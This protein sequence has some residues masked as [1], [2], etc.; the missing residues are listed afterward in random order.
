MKNKV[1]VC[2]WLLLGYVFFFKIPWIKVVNSYLYPIL[3]PSDVKIFYYTDIEDLAIAVDKEDSI[4]ICKIL[5]K[6]PE[7]INE[8]EDVFGS[9][10]LS[11]AVE[12][13]KYISIPILIKY[14]ADPTCCTDGLLYTYTPIRYSIKKNNDI[15]FN[16]LLK[17]SYMVYKE[18]LVDALNYCILDEKRSKYYF[19]MVNLDIIKYDT[20]G[21]LI[22]TAIREGRY[23]M[24]IDLLQR[25]ACFKNDVEFKRTYGSKRLLTDYLEDK[26]PTD[27]L[28]CQYKHQF[29]SMLEERGLY[30]KEEK[31]EENVD[32]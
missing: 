15:I 9:T 20:D 17:S 10:V 31:K 28:Q 32:D 8:T 3:T 27:S 12:K 11:Y 6:S 4:S 18:N 26:D 23:D 1:K 5:D 2:L 19:Q 22:N 7:L 16:E 30:K 24:A 25:G 14:G 13:D 21:E 29:I